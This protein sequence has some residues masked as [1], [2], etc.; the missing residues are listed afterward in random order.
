MANCATCGNGLQDDAAFCGNCGASQSASVP[1]AAAPPP[2]Y[3][4]IPVPPPPPSY[5]G[6]PPQAAP[7]A[8]AT[9]GGFSVANWMML[10]HLSALA[11]VL[12]PLGNVLGPLVVWLVKRTDIPQVDV[13][14]KEALNFQI[15]MTIAL[16]ISGFL[17]LFLVGFVMLAVIGI[18][19][20]VM[21]VVAGVQSA[22]GEP[23]RYPITLRLI[24]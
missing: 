5:S 14:G 23:Y 17:T 18:Y 19:D 11:G 22:K 15:T 3:A 24:Q 9:A 12:C 4:N 10:C 2:S 1:A 21:T 13:E 20:L 8:V 7:Q 6:A 16:V